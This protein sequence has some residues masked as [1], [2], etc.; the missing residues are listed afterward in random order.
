MRTKK[1]FALTMSGGTLLAIG[2]CIP[3]LQDLFVQTLISRIVQ[4]LVSA[5]TTASATT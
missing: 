1:W 4:L 5:F 2:G 3:V